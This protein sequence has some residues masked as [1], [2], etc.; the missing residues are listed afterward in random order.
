[1]NQITDDYP[2]VFVDAKSV[3]LFELACKVARTEIPVLVRGP[4]GTGKEVLARVLHESSARA[5]KPFVAL[6][7]AAI[8]EHLVKTRCLGTRKARLPVPTSIRS[9]SSNRQPAARYFSMR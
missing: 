8:P 9:V 3:E 1:M 5:D 4:S 2:F 7:C 6:N